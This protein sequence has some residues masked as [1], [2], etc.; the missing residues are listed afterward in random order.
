ML[1]PI[2]AAVAQNDDPWD[3]SFQTFSVG[4]GHPY[5]TQYG[6]VKWSDGFPV[7]IELFQWAHRKTR[8]RQNPYPVA[9][10]ITNRFAWGRIKKFDFVIGSGHVSI[11]IQI[12]PT[13]HIY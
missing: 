5:A 11:F 4:H 6:V 10:I 12:N 8:F 1:D 13:F 3:S 7:M 9:L 2:K